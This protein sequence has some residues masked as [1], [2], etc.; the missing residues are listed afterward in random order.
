MKGSPKGK[1]L[2]HLINSLNYFE[3][4]VQRSVWRICVWILELK[5]PRC[6]YSM[7]APSNNKWTFIP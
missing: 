3:G 4:N 5:G 6:F 2:D 7:L 1:Y